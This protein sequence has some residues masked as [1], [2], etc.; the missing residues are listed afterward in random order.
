MIASELSAHLKNIT[1]KTAA[2]KYIEAK[3]TPCFSHLRIVFRI[4]F[5]SKS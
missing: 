3:L 1:V 5:I 2:E 4:Y